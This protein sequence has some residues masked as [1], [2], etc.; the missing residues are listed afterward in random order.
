MIGTHQ[1]PLEQRKRIL[2]VAFLGGS[3]ISAI[4]NT[5]R[6]AIEMDGRFKLV[7]G[8]FSRKT[9]VNEDSA[10]FYGVEA[11]RTYAYLDRML[12]A[13]QGRVDV[14]LVL[15]PTDQHTEEVMSCLRAGYP[16]ICEKALA[17]SVS[18]GQAIRQVLEENASFLAVTYNYSGYPMVRELRSLVKSGQLG[19]IRQ[20]QC[21][22]PQEGFIALNADGGPRVPQDWRL[23]DGEIST[24]SLDLGTHLHSLVHFVTGAHPLRLVARCSTL[25]HFTEIVDTVSCLVEYSDGLHCD[26]W[27]SKVALGQRNGLKIRV[28]GVLGSA[29]WVQEAPEYLTLADNR[30]NRQIVDRASA[31]LL[32][33]TSPRYNRFKAGHPAGFIEAFANYYYDVA[34]ALEGYLASAP[35]E[36]PYV[37]GI[38]EATEALVLFA[39]A[40]L[41]ARE[42]CW[43]E[44]P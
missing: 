17:S 23:R 29:E 37:F 40:E 25:G 15:T 27:Y 32:E 2:R 9:E 43:V 41:S 28:Y 1:L 6:I 31:N 5:H 8:C 7:A 13:E 10:E 35:G 36:A 19:S 38:D 14:I 33:A 16:V 34:D 26:F 42:R 22:M 44:I 4:G 11:S 18:G 12:E 24:V 21:E 20:I 39:A 3:Y 30:G